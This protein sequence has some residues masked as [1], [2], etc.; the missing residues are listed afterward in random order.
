MSYIHAPF[1]LS[2]VQEPDTH[3]KEACVGPSVCLRSTVKRKNPFPLLGSE[4]QFLG[5]PVSSLVYYA[6]CL[7]LQT[8]LCH[9]CS[10]PSISIHTAKI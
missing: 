6:L 4:P 10:V 5:H 1:A 8:V 7:Y 2:R 9:S 3:G